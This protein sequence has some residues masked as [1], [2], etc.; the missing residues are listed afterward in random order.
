MNANSL[1]IFLNFCDSIKDLDGRALDLSFLAPVLYEEAKK[2]GADSNLLSLIGSW[3]DTLSD[4]DLQEIIKEYDT[5]SSEEAQRKKDE[6]MRHFASVIDSAADAVKH[7]RTRV[8]GVEFYAYFD[9]ALNFTTER[10]A[11]IT[12]RFVSY[13][14]RVS[15]LPSKN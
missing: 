1:A 7:F 8:E 3:G 12:M 5:A 11:E 9:K 2:R 6:A 4:S 15:A 10:K 13:P 14:P